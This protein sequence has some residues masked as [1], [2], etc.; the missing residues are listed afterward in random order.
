MALAT[1]L[2]ILLVAVAAGWGAMRRRRGTARLDRRLR[3][4][5]ARDW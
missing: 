2:G 1:Y 4:L 3:E 5:R